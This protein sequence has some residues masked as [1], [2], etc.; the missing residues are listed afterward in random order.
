MDNLEAN[1]VDNLEVNLVDSQMLN[2]VDSWGVN[3]E[4]ILI[5]CLVNNLIINQE[6]KE[7]YILIGD[8]FIMD[9]MDILMYL[10]D[11][12]MHRVVTM[13][14]ILIMVDNLEV[15][16]MVLINCMV[17]NNRELLEVSLESHC[18]IDNIK[19]LMGFKAVVNILNQQTIQIISKSTQQIFPNLL[20]NI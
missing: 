13:D 8:S 20:M 5:V 6:D 11:L 9:S 18:F 3:L 4:D 12:F 1:L 2:Q 10:R 15:V 7:D 16:D 14:I 19:D 17:I